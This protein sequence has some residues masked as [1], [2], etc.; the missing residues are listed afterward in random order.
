[1]VDITACL[2]GKQ[3]DDEVQSEGILAWRDM[4]ACTI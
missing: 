4:A 1:M 3:I 2:I